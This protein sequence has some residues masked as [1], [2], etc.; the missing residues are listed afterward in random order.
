MDS[1]QPPVRPFTGDFIGLLRSDIQH[2]EQQM[3][4]DNARTRIED[5]NGKSCR[6][7]LSELLEQFDE[8]DFRE[9]AGL[10]ED[11]KLTRKIFVVIAVEEIISKA[12]ANNWGLCI[13]NGRDYA[14]KPAKRDL[15]DLRERADTPGAAPGGL[16]EIS[17]AV[18]VRPFGPVSTF[19]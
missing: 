18:R 7:V 1:R 8:L 11:A 13:K 15:R 2:R 14:D 16:S 19:R 9:R 6:R 12:T 3:R 5:L 10:D 17:V 4:E